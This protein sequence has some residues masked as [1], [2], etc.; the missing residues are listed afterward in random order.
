MERQELGL[1]SLL[2]FL[3][4]MYSGCLGIPNARILK[5]GARVLQLLGLSK[6]EMLLVQCGRL[7]FAKFVAYN[8]ASAQLLDRIFT[9]YCS[10]EPSFSNETPLVVLDR[11]FPMKLC[12]LY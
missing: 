4:F 9:S 12:W 8:D 5:V 2:E 11:L 7:L 1:V 3:E 10:F 6:G